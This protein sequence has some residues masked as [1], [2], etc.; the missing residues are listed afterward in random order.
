[1]RLDFFPIFYGRSYMSLCDGL[2]RTEL[3]NKCA[4]KVEHSKP[5]HRRA[6][7]RGIDDISIQQFFDPLTREKNIQLLIKS[8]TNHTFSFSKLKGIPIK[9]ENSD[10]DRL[11]TAP[12]VQDRIV[13]KALLAT[14]NPVLYPYINTGASYAGVKENIFKKDKEG[15]NTKKAIEKLIQH[16]SDGRLWVLKADIEKFFDRVP[17]DKLL[18]KIN[19]FTSPDDSLSK[20]IKSI[21]YFQIGNINQLEKNPRIDIPVPEI[22]ISQGSALSPLF[23]NAYLEDFD[24]AVIKNFGDILIRYVDDVLLFAKTEDDIKVIK[25]FIEAYLEGKGL[26]LSRKEEKTYISNI[27]GKGIEFLGLR[28]DRNGIREKDL[29]KIIVHIQHDIFDFGYKEYK[30]LSTFPDKVKCM[31]QKIHGIFN[32]YSYYHTAKLAETINS[33][34]NEQRKRYPK[35]EEL[36]AIEVSKS[37]RITSPE[38]W[39]ELLTKEH[40]FNITG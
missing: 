10:K 26:N 28:I 18:E 33:V 15:F 40:L 23:A 37:N 30:H 31:N 12:S 7:S 16:V 39:R 1:M 32:Y 6:K 29:P 8:L 35:Y 11:I 24:R 19:G 38:E 3:I 4:N 21:I 17:K 5:V 34:I 2:C 9:K 27:K 14:L 20:L 13:H 36:K 22:G 25:V